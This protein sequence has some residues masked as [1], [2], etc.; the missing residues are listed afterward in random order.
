MRERHVRHG[1]DVYRVSE[2]VCLM[3]YEVEN[4]GAVATVLAWHRE[5]INTCCP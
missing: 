5:G 1:A 3:Y 4:N 2:D